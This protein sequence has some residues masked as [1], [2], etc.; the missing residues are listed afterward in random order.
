MRSAHSQDPAV[1]LL[2]DLVAATA[3]SMRRLA[4]NGWSK[5]DTSRRVRSKARPASEVGGTG[6]QEEGS[7]GRVVLGPPGLM[8]TSLLR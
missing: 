6:D 5:Q 2:R 3:K 7:S 8:P 4:P 1:E